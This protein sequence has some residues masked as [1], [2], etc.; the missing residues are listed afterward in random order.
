MASRFAAGANDGS[1]SFPS[2]PEFTIVSVADSRSAIAV[3]CSRAAR[4][5]SRGMQPTTM[6]T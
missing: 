1:L 4:P 2:T 3:A 5:S 6:F